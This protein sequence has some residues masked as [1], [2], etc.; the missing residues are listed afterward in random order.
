MRLMKAD[1]S[2]PDWGPTVRFASHSRQREGHHPYL[3]EIRRAAGYLAGGRSYCLVK[4]VLVSEQ[5]LDVLL[6]RVLESWR[7]MPSFE[8][9]GMN[10]HISRLR[11]HV[12]LLSSACLRFR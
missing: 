11:V 7:S 5:G 4:I 12:D 3:V 2:L 10:L 9:S 8:H 6:S 1:L